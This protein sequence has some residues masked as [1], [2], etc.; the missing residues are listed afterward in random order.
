MPGTPSGSRRMRRWRAGWQPRAGC[1]PGAEDRGRSAEP[2]RYR[3][4]APAQCSAAGA[5]RDI[6][7]DH[8]SIDLRGSDHPWSSKPTTDVLPAGRRTAPGAVATP[9]NSGPYARLSTMAATTLVPK[10]LRSRRP[11]VRVP[12]GAPTPRSRQTPARPWRLASSVND[13]AA[14]PLAS[15]REPA[16]APGSGRGRSRRSCI[17]WR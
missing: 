3:S 13:D 8:G 15:I 2:R 9:D 4:S 5:V 17:R 7:A 14:V 1:A 16:S 11:W 12:P 10:C 6:R